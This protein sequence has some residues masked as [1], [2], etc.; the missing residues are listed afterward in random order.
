MQT[1]YYRLLDYFVHIVDCGSL[2][3]AAQ[4]LNVSP[5][6]IS[7]ALSDL[8]ENIGHTLII[9]GRGNL[10]LTDAGR[11]IYEQSQHMMT[12]AAG[13]INALKTPPRDIG[14]NVGITLPSELSLCWFPEVLSVFRKLQ[15]NVNVSILA[16]DESTDLV[17]IGCELALRAEYH[18]EKPI[19][20]NPALCLAL[21]LVCSPNILPSGKVSSKKLIESMPFIGFR[22][23]TN[24]WILQGVHRTTGKVHKFK[25]NPTVSVNSAIY[26]KSLAL[27][28]HGMSLV[29]SPSVT[30]EL[31][32]GELISIAQS[33]QFGYVKLRV[34]Y[35]DQYPSDAAQVLGNFIES[36]APEMPERLD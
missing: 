2:L 22:F 3:G 16:S 36:W 7:K 27:Y 14:G 25:T 18:L 30:R 26:G 11:Y 20:A 31:Q 10:E 1:R 35:R 23:R 17:K 21:H 29:L 5:P 15:P 8:E 6:V 4:H 33:H 9:R 34:I 28:G 12:V 32:T 24:N 19:T 13:A